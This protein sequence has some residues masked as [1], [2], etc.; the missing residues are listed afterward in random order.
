MSVL[1]S[2]LRF[3]PQRANTALAGFPGARRMGHSESYWE[4]KKQK[5]DI[6]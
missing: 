5:D 4:Q 6:V 3:P 2:T 1:P